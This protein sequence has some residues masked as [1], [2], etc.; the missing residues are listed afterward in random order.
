VQTKFTGF[1]R[2][3]QKADQ[4]LLTGIFKIKLLRGLSG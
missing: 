4:S 3:I 1:A 2:T